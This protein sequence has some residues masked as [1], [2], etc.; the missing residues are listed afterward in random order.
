[1]AAGLELLAQLPVVLDDAVEDDREL[2]VVAGGEGMRVLLGHAAVR[3]PA[4]VAEAGGRL[5]PVRPGLLLGAG[6]VAGAAPDVA[7]LQ[8]HVPRELPL[9]ADRELVD[10]RDPEVAPRVVD[11]LA[12]HGHEAQ[13]GAGR[14]ADA[15]R[16]GVVEVVERRAVRVERGDEGRGDAEALREADDDGVHEVPAVAA[17]H[18]GPVVEL[19]ARS[20]APL[21]VVLV[22]GPGLARVPVHPREAQAAAQLQGR[23]ARG[24][25]AALHRVGSLGVEDVVHLVVPLAHRAVEVPAQPQVE[26]ELAVDLPV[27]LDPRREVLPAVDGEHVEVDVSARR[28]AQEQRRE[29]V[30]RERVAAVEIALR[31]GATEIEPHAAVAADLA[32]ILRIAQVGAEAHAVGSPLHRD[33]GLY[34]PGI[35]RLV[36][37]AAAAEVLEVGHVDARE[38]LDGNLVRQAGREAELGEA[39]AEARIRARQL[40][41]TAARG[42]DVEHRA[43]AEDVDPVRDSRVVGPLQRELAVL[44]GARADGG[45]VAD[46]VPLVLPVA[47]EHP[48]TAPEVLVDLGHEVVELVPVDVLQIPQVALPRRHARGRGV[49]QREEAQ[50]PGGHG[51]D[52]IGGD[53]V[54]GERVAHPDAVHVAPRGGVVDRDEPPGG[55][56]EL[57]EVA[58]PHGLRRHGAEER[59][60][61][62][63]A[64]ALVVDHEEGLVLAVVDAGDLHGA[65]ELDTVLVEEVIGLGQAPGVVEQ[66]V[67][68]ERPAPHEL[69]GRAVERVGARLQRDVHDAPRRAAVLGVVGVRHDLELTDGVH[70]RDVRDVVS[71]LDRVVGRAV[72]QELVVAVLSAVDRP[73]GDGSIVEGALVDGVAVVVHARHQHRQHERVARVERELDDAAVVDHRAAVGLARVQQRRFRRDVRLLAEVSHRQLDVDGGGLA[74]LEPQPAAVLLEARQLDGEGIGARPQEGNGVVPVCGGDDGRRLVGIGVLGRDRSPGHRGPGGIGDA[75]LDGGPELLR[76]HRRG[77][78]GEDDRGEQPL[79]HGP[80]CFDGPWVGRPFPGWH[81]RRWIRTR[82]KSGA[83]GSE[84]TRTVRASIM[85]RPSADAAATSDERGSLWIR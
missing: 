11:A 64:V 3:R 85:G 68:V 76:E 38:H 32:R 40:H 73:V 4:G 78:A 51:V 20:Q 61:R 79:S 23:E 55:I 75:S 26:R 63:L 5:R 47:D 57:A 24:V 81:D 41:V 28:R 22:E 25:D 31:E 49:G 43:G 58:A 35:G 71:A 17:A 60:G 77:Q 54:A 36:A 6:Q 46:L 83:C 19:K 13:R 12:Q 67:R 10:V 65:V 1:M 8:D 48:V 18:H 21:D 74:H 44:R 45:G 62:S 2:R 34:R 14:L 27:V 56:D 80:S 7:H 50:E 53:D 29:A 42:A 72:E 9:E 84:A 37:E 16:K 69:V 59:V 39:E 15:G 30:P 82:S 33:V 66:V 52:A 70:R